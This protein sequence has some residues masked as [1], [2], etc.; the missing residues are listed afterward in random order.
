MPAVN[1]AC[2]VCV[3]L[4]QT[5]LKWP[6]L[7]QNIQSVL[8]PINKL[9]IIKSLLFGIFNIFNVFNALHGIRNA[10]SLVSDV[11]MAIRAQQV[12]SAKF[13]LDVVIKKRFRL[14]Y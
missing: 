6:L 10:A 14:A 11:F 2:T 13:A 1:T 8:L 5:F 3:S 7:V 12:A 9:L 4:A